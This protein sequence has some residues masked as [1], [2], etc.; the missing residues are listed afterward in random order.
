M[1]GS[2][3]PAEDSW[4]IDCSLLCVFLHSVLFCFFYWYD[5]KVNRKK[6]PKATLDNNK[7]HMQH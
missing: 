4:E 2:R 1:H 6:N 5:N 3:N 7:T